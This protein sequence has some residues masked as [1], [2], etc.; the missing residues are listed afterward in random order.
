MFII[1]GE[2]RTTG[3]LIIL[4]PKCSHEPLIVQ[5]EYALSLAKLEEAENLYVR[6]SVWECIHN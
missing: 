1:T 6:V 2:D 4:H 3:H 5:K